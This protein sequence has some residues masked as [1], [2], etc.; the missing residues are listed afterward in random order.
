MTTISW[1]NFNSKID[2]K[3]INFYEFGCG[4]LDGQ[5]KIQFDLKI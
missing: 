2:N 4:N 5:F 1:L 3:E